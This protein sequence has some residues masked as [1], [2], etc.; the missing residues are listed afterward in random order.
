MTNKLWKVASGV[1][2]LLLLT[3]CG[4]SGS[5]STSSPAAS[6]GG[7]S[8]A[9]AKLPAGGKIGI[10]AST[11]TSEVEK[12]WTE[13]ATAA[14][15]Q[16]GWTA[17]IVDSANDPGKMQSAISGFVTDKVAGIITIAIDGAPMAPALKAAKDA[18]IPVIATGIGIDP[19]GQSLFSAFYAP[20]D[21]QLGQAAADYLKTKVPSG[22]DYVMLDLTAVYGAHAPIVA[23]QKILDAAGFKQ[24][25]SHDISV[26][27]IV[28]STGKGSADLIQAHPTA[29]FMFGC[30]DFTAPITVPALKAAG[31]GDVI[32]TVRYD[33]LS[34]LDLIRNGA[35]VATAAVNAD[36]GV[37]TAI[38][39]ILAHAASGAAIDPA[40]DKGIYQYKMV[41]KANLPEK[42]KYV[43]DPAE[44]IST[45]VG[46]WKTAY[47]L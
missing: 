14:L 31:H 20:S 1:S 26:A 40:A 13:T 45:F 35:P 17:V 5:S 32:Q 46:Q 16:I 6:S 37:L 39:Q 43:F 19:A 41:D 29:K 8:S 22:S 18:N 11:L 10:V 4:S 21:D 47:G 42:G 36:S 24:V 44:Q 9:A 12:H 15:K 2:A 33:N 38:S 3:A 34:T 30:C 28:G 25:G 23:G 7:S 27:D